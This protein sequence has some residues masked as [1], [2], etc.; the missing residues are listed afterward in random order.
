MTQPE[1]IERPDE[2]WKYPYV[3]AMLDFASNFRCRVVKEDMARVNYQ[4]VVDLHFAH[5]TPGVLGF[6]DE[7]CLNHDI[8][9]RFRE[10]AENYRLEISKREDVKRFLELA[11]PFSLV[12][13]EPIE[14]VLEDL[15]PGLESGKQGSEEGFVELMGYID[16]IREHTTQRSETKYTQD[17]FRDEFGL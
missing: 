5:P 12:R 6:L 9:P 13:A 10:Q 7:F 11:R 16:E 3:A 14:I 1:E 17:Y 8:T 15:F 4:I 2:P